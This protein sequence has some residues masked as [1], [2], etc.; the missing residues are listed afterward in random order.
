MIILKEEYL[1]MGHSNFLKKE[2][3]SPEQ[4]R[5]ET[6]RSQRYASMITSYTRPG[7]KRRYKIKR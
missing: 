2:G 4:I 1:N 5:A 6:A 7:S 3:F